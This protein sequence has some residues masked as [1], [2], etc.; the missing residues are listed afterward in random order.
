MPMKS[1]SLKTVWE[2]IP[3]VVR[4]VVIGFLVFAIAGSLVWTALLSFLPP[5]WPFLAMAAVLVVYVQYLRGRWWPGSTVE[6][7][8][9]NFR[10]TRM[11]VRVWIW[12]L[13]AAVFLVLII[14]S[15]LVVTFRIVEFPAE[16]WSLG[17]DFGGTAAWVAWSFVVVAAATAAITEEVGFRG[18]MQVPLENRYGP[19]AAITI[20]S[21]VFLVSH[22]HQAWAPL[23]LIHVF[24]ASVLW[25]ILARVSGSL[26]PGII[27][28]TLVD[29]VNF[30]YWWTDLAGRFEMETIERTG[31]DRHFV[32]WVL[33]L[34][35]SF[36]AF[37]RASI[38]TREAGQRSNNGID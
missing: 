25:G 7:K 4:A 16:A 13:L 32:L 11:P 37:W 9:T 12:S 2:R 1:D 23:V 30:S 10:A 24:G 6:F 15:S 22:L 17:F 14:Q 36:I 31:V 33:I 26:I 29:V 28:H 19:G 18:Y 21:V 20:V 38:R 8:R 34:L 27:S 3:L 35:L 5:P